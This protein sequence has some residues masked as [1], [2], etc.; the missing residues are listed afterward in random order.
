MSTQTELDLNDFNMANIDE[1]DT[2]KL[3][4]GNDLEPK[5]EESAEPAPAQTADEPVEP[6]VA[7]PEPTPAG[8]EPAESTQVDESAPK[9]DAPRDDIRVP[10]SRLDDEI[11]KR[12]QAEQE[13]ANLREFISR[14]T[15]QQAAQQGQPQ[16]EEQSAFDEAAKIKAEYD[17][18]IEGDTE[19]ALAIRREISEHQ[20]RVLLQEVQ[21]QSQGI[22]ARM[23]DDL[24][25]NERL[26]TVV[27]TF[28]V[29]NEA[30]EQFNPNLAQ[31]AVR[32][33]DAYV[34]QHGMTRTQAL[35]RTVMDLVEAGVLTPAQARQT[36]QAAPALAPTPMSAPA[37][38]Q[39]QDPGLERKV[40]AINKQPPSTNAGSSRGTTDNVK[41]NPATM[42]QD[43]WESLPDSIKSQFLA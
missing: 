8:E 15:K 1:I 4:F 29:F 24:A 13:A 20:R 7:E 21:M 32:M 3:D 41:V 35:E 27:A 16:Q 5:A 9:A 40:A 25:F 31:M 38:A 18:L 43:E 19:K 10:K 6:T 22:D 17:A 2:S 28:P 36:E 12:R 30:S 26:Q 14:L 11:A 37:P 39:K 34:A 23:R 33:G 42:T